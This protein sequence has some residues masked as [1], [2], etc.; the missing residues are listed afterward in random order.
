MECYLF[1]LKNERDPAIHNNVHGFG[2]QY[3][4]CNKPD[5]ESKKKKKRKK[6][7]KRKTCMIPLTC[8]MQ[9]CQIHRSR[10]YKCSY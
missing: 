10:E 6:E 9:K 5:I 3:T 2:G 8:E 1:S 4:K 7:R